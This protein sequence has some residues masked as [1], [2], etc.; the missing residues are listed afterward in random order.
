MRTFE[1]K[2]R[3]K[4]DVTLYCFSMLTAGC[5]WYID[6]PP[7]NIYCMNL[8]A[9]SSRGDINSTYFFIFLFV[10]F[11]VFFI[12]FYFSYLS[13]LF[14]KVFCCWQLLTL[15]LTPTPFFHSWTTSEKVTSCWEV[16]ECVVPVSNVFLFFFIPT[17]YKLWQLNDIF[18]M[19]DILTQFWYSMLILNSMNFST[20]FYLLRC[21]FFKKL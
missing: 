9:P 4:C 11:W 1:L 10:P 7:F 13:L 18:M 2:P 6:I 17:L 16:C 21:F 14:L 3:S 20:L 15:P 5:F 19:N 8:M 12:F